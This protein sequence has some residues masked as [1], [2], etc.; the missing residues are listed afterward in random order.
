MSNNLFMQ[1]KDKIPSDSYVYMKDKLDGADEKVVNQ[2]SMMSLKDPTM[3][4]I[5]SLILGGLGVDR[6]YKG[7]IGLGVL[8]LLTFGGLGIWAIVDWFLIS[9]GVKKNNLD[10]IN[11]I[12]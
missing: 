1:L 12:F 5:L 10:K 7:D 4:L 2:L 6:F 9:K 8:K 3:A 11:Q